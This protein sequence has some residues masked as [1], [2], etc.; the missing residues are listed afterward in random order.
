MCVGVGGLLDPGGG[1]KKWPCCICQM[2]PKY[3]TTM[4]ISRE[5]VNSQSANESPLHK[6][7]ECTCTHA[8]NVHARRVITMFFVEV[9][10]VIRA[11]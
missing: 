3:P 1:G 4:P 10:G 7:V 9:F 6:Q 5:Q 2:R 8:H 11:A